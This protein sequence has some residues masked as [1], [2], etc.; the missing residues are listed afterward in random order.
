M[1]SEIKRKIEKYIVEII[2]AHK[3]E[4]GIPGANLAGDR[5]LIPLQKSLSEDEQN[6]LSEKITQIVLLKLEEKRKA[7]EIVNLP[8]LSYTTNQ[9]MISIEI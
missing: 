5:I 9:N 1:K 4:L 7:G 2:N 6:K 8:I 3:D